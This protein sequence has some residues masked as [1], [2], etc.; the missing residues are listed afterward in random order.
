[1]MRRDPIVEEVRKHRQAIARE[2]GNDVKAIVAA[3]EGDD[4]VETTPMVSFPAKHLARA[5]KHR[6]LRTKRRPNKALEPTVRT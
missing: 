2:H 3:L 5:T 6:Q 1:M 4:S